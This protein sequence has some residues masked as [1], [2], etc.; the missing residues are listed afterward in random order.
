[1]NMKRIFIWES[2]DPI[3]GSWHSGGGLAIIADDL[4][5]A[6][7]MLEYPDCTAHAEPSDFEAAIEATED[8]MFVFPDAGCC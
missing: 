5:A 2:V 6:R 7:A 1:M 8:K 3:S 4:A